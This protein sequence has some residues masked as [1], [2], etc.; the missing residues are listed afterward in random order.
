MQLKRMLFLLMLCGITSRG[1][2]SL[3]EEIA[4]G[5]KKQSLLTEQLL[6]AAQEGD[7]ATAEKILPGIN[8]VDVTN[9][10]GFTPLIL[11]SSYGHTNFVKMLISAGADLNYQNK[12][13]QT[14]VMC[15]NAARHT[16]T[17]NELL[18]AGADVNK[19]DITGGTALIKA[20][21][22]GN[23]KHIILLL[24]A[25]ADPLLSMFD[26]TTIRTAFTEWGMQE[27]LKDELVTLYAHKNFEQILK[28]LYPQLWPDRHI[29]QALKQYEKRLKR[30]KSEK[31]EGK[32]Q[33]DGLLI[34]DLSNIV[35]GYIE[36]EKETSDGVA[37]QACCVIS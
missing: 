9:P 6:K 16:E 10:D 8:T 24:N 4:P 21:I 15:A 34:Q 3:H 33:L 25:N 28:E 2:Y 32:K 30:Y 36:H 5:I 1:I 31:E 35:D 17:L 27:K 26:P 19:Q 13:G 18:H 20:A 23:K 29:Q 11:A 37:P 14:A 22:A 12:N 7:V